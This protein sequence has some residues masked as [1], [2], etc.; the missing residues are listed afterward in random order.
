M[1]NRLDHPT[2]ESI[3]QELNGRRPGDSLSDVARDLTDAH[4]HRPGLFQQD[5]AEVNQKLHDQGILPGF[6]IV[7]VQGQDLVAKKA[8]ATGAVSVFDATDTDRHRQLDTPAFG[9]NINGRQATIN[10]DGSG[11]VTAKRGDNDPSSLSRD[12]LQAQGTANPTDT[13]V[14]N[15]VKELQ[16][17]NGKPYMHHLREGQTVKLPASVVSGDQSQFTSDRAN[18]RLTQSKQ[19]ILDPVVDAKTI[20]MDYSGLGNQSSMTKD[21][22]TSALNSTEL[23]TAQRKALQFMQTDFDQLKNTGAFLGGFGALVGGDRIWLGGLDQ[24]Q[25]DQD[26]AAEVVALDQGL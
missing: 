10:P 12:I 18:D 16:R 13:Q 3:V 21:E 17:E 11:Q 25:Q 23:S 8:D 9:N 5:L 7:G 14:A 26:Q 15:Y 22:I 4:F 20:L 24:Y 2:G 19:N 6:N 1:T